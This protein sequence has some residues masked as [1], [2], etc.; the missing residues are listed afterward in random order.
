MPPFLVRKTP[1]EVSEVAPVSHQGNREKPFFW[2]RI[3]PC[4]YAV[5]F[6][7]SNWIS[8]SRR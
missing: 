5:C 2:N 4:C 1:G 7:S 6:S 3:G 8:Y